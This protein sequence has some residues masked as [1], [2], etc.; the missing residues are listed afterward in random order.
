MLYLIYFIVPESP[1]KLNILWKMMGHQLPFSFFFLILASIWL[2]G[3]LQVSWT[4][5]ARLAELTDRLCAQWI[6]GIVAADHSQQQWHPDAW[7]KLIPTARNI[8]QHP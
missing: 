5:D 1:F 3:H 7:F 4:L 6:I 8:I 2:A